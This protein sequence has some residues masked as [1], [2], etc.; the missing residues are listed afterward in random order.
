MKVASSS[1][2]EL[3]PK[4]TNREFFSKSADRLRPDEVEDQL[5]SMTRELDSR[6]TKHELAA[7]RLEE[8]NAADLKNALAQSPPCCCRCCSGRCF[9]WSPFFRPSHL[10]LAYSGYHSQGSTLWAQSRPATAGHTVD[11]RRKHTECLWR[12]HTK[13]ESG[14]EICSEVRRQKCTPEDAS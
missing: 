10:S 12:Q 11:E 13:R 14:F 6:T 9:P 5:T 1:L 2:F 3:S 7:K 4:P 8:Q